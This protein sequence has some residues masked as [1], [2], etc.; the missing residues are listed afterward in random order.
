MKKMNETDMKMFL[1]FSL[2]DYF[3]SL[4]RC[5]SFED[6]LFQCVFFHSVHSSPKWFV[7]PLNI[8]ILNALKKYPE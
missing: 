3:V 4:F 8:E 5:S 1:N 6:Q 2:C 7:T